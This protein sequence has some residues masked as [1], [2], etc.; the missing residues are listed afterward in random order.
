[1]ILA[2]LILIQSGVLAILRRLFP[3]LSRSDE[4]ADADD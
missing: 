2:P 3:N 1:V 4:N